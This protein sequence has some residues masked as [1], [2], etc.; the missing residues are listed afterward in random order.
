MAKIF[1]QNYKYKYRG[2]ESI[3]TLRFRSHGNGTSYKYEMRGKTISGTMELDLSRF[4]KQYSRA[5]YDLD[6]MVMTD[7]IPYMPMDT[8][9]FINVTRAM[10]AAIAGSGKVVAAAPP[11]GRF[12]YNGKVMIGERTRSAFAERGEKKVVTDRNLQYSTSAHPQVESH[13]FEKAKRNHGA[14]WLKKTKRTAGGG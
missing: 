11:M 8:G 1:D 12:L 4:E 13:W 9:T 3:K 14:Q 5:Q 6:S 10:S 2:K 7:M